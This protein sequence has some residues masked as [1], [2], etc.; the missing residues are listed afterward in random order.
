MREREREWKWGGGKGERSRKRYKM[1]RQRVPEFSPEF[2]SNSIKVIYCNLKK[3]LH[4]SLKKLVHK[5]STTTQP[6]LN[7]NGWS[8]VVVVLYAQLVASCQHWPCQEKIGY[9]EEW[10]VEKNREGKNN[11]K[12]E[13]GEKKKKTEKLGERRERERRG[14]SGRKTILQF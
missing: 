13:R 5:N 7:I 3:L 6:T 11:R 12:K 1:D 8:N 10:E 9:K 14:G 2:F 4:P